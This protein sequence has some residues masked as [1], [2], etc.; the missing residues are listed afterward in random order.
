MQKRDEWV[1]KAKIFDKIFQAGTWLKSGQSNSMTLDDT[2]CILAQKGTGSN[3][4]RFS[5]MLRDIT[6]DG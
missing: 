5:T 3:L 4:I 1:Y 2:F 6:L